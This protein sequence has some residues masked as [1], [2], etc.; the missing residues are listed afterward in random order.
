MTFSST[1]F[2][3]LV[4]MHILKEKSELSKI[5]LLLALLLPLVINI[6]VRLYHTN[7]H[8]I[9]SS[10]ATEAPHTAHH[11]HRHYPE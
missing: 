6:S 7:Y 9:P 8:R 10:Y 4:Y 2:Q 5:I 1:S 11:R 3:L